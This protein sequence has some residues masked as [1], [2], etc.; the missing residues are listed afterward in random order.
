MSHHVLFAGRPLGRRLRYNFQGSSMM[1]S[2]NTLCMALAGLGVLCTTGTAQAVHLSQ[3]RQGQALIYPYYTVRA[4]AEGNAYDSLLTVVNKTGSG[5]AVKVTFREGKAGHAVL[6][7]NLYLSPYDVWTAAITPSADGAQI[8]T[9]DTSCSFTNVRAATI[10]RGGQPFSNRLF[11][12]ELSDGEDE[13]L[14]RT[15]EGFV[16]IIEMGRIINVA[17]YNILTAI[18]HT[19]HGAPPNCDAIKDGGDRATQPD[20]WARDSIVYPDRGWASGAPGGLVGS[21]TLINVNAARA[22]GYD[23]VA[24]EGFY[25]GSDNWTAADIG[26]AARVPNTLWFPS[27]TENPNLS[28][29]YPARSYVLDDGGAIHAEWTGNTW[30]R[31]HRH[32]NGAPLRSVFLQGLDAVSSVLMRNTIENE[33]VNGDEVLGATDWVVTMPTKNLYYDRAPNAGAGLTC[34]SGSVRCLQ[35][36]SLFASPFIAGGT[37]DAASGRFYDRE[38]RTYAL[39]TDS[40]WGLPRD[41][42][43]YTKWSAN[44][45]ELKR[46][47]VDR[48]VFNAMNWGSVRVAFSEGWVQVFLP[49]A[50]NDQQALKSDAPGHRYTFTG[51]PITGFAAILYNNGAVNGGSLGQV[52]ASYVATTPHSYT[53]SIVSDVR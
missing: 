9:H 27:G 8:T 39:C 43:I 31:G 22:I 53:R 36:R 40:G 13:S 49:R 37:P 47:G 4:N 19:A 3:D 30:V 10:A 5:K 7:F 17:P 50:D 2:F 11:S 42:C 14:D 32:D 21:M 51:L 18:T 33:F 26:T 29:A 16:E 24:L 44:V 46:T 6:S 15:R 28:M 23:A 52:W 1:K 34:P 25:N 41:P 35:P 20:D 38:A 48:T 12:G 45:L